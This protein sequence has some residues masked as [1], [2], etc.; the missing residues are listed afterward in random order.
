M[1]ADVI[2]D[3]LALWPVAIPLAAAALS[4]LVRR[5][6][7]L[8]RSVMEGAVV[9]MLLSSVA[10]L[11]HVDRSG[12]AIMKYGGWGAPFGVTFVADGLSAALCTVAGVVALAV[13]AVECHRPD[14]NA[15]NPGTRKHF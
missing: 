10:L 12:P 11:I 3:G 14:R 1:T 8:Q 13:A 15:R 7:L 6:Q 5:R 2:V 9:L 4:M